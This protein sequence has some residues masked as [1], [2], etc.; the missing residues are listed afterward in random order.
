MAHRPCWDA[1]PRS[2][3]NRGKREFSAQLYYPSALT[4]AGAEIQT[5]NVWADHS[6]FAANR[7]F[8]FAGGTT[9]FDRETPAPV[10]IFRL[11][12]DGHVAVVCK[13]ENSAV[14]EAY[15]R[16]QKL[17]AMGAFLAVIRTIG[18]G[19][20]DEGTLH[21]GQTHD[22]QATAAEIRASYRPW[23][24]SAQAKPAYQGDHP[25]YQYDERTRAFLEDWSL[26]EL[27]NRREYQT[28]LELTGP[29]EASYA[30][31]LQSEFRLSAD[32]ARLAAVKV[33][34]GLI[35]ARLEVPN[36][37]SADLTQTYFPSTPLHQAVLRQDR[38]AFDAA[39]ARPQSTG[40]LAVGRTRQAA[41]DILSDT[42]ADAVEWPYGLDRLLSAGADA[43]RANGFGKTPLMVAAH[44]DRPD[45]A[46]KLLHAGANVNATTHV[47]A[48]SWMTGPK[49]SGRSALMYAA[50]N[51]GP[52]TIK[53][54][55]DAG[56]DPAAKDSDGNDMS[57]YLKRNPRF[58]AAERSLGVVGL[59]KG[60]E[61]FSGPSYSC[62]KA[63]TG[64]E[65]A[66]C[67]SEVLR[68]FDAQIARAFVALNGK[69]DSTVVGEQRLWLQSRDRSCGADVD[70][71]AQLMRT[72]LRYLQ[73]RGYE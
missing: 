44:F 27:W 47:P 11:F 35:G 2:R 54:L 9:A 4:R 3:W 61:S 26:E 67:G 60:A 71:L 22:A 64:T 10:E 68:S 48:D 5:G 66:I 19:G 43:N 55:L 28:L 53:V 72:R 14:E 41:P 50:G 30:N 42:V 40:A 32:D 36:D 16:M 25:Y 1:G 56:A 31:Y 29:T 7:R 37:F 65:Q 17:P 24:T 69:A 13:I 34:Q 18:A 62:A 63:R 20:E 58:T 45:S 57:F 51:A 73:D 23:A 6:L 33:I 70:C 52:A 8:Y 21:S 49:R 12:A 46:R 59:A 15:G 39:L 38:A